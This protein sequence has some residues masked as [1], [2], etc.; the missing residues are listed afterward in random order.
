MI[1]HKW[2]TSDNKINPANL[3]GFYGLASLAQENFKIQNVS[4]KFDD[5]EDM[6]VCNG[7]AG[8]YGAFSYNIYLFDTK[9]KKGNKKQSNFYPLHKRCE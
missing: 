3:T 1:D 7:K 9:L 5:I 4:N 2:I 6:A 8:G